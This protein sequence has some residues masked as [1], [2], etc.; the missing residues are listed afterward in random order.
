M[1]ESGAATSRREVRRNER[2]PRCGEDGA[3][4]RARVIEDET[5]HAHG[6]GTI[7]LAWCR[8]GCHRLDRR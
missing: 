5:G 2:C 7:E 3:T 8:H 4:V 1:V 6:T